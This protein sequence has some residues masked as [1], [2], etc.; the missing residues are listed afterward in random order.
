M[1]GKKVS[2]ISVGLMCLFILIS[3]SK[4]YETITLKIDFP[5]QSGDLQ[6]YGTLLS[7][8]HK[9]P[10]ET[11][12]NFAVV[13]NDNFTAKFVI[14]P[15]TAYNIGYN[16][17]NRLRIDGISVN[18]VPITSYCVINFGDSPE[19]MYGVASFIL[20]KDN[21]GQYQVAPDPNCNAIVR[22]VK[23]NITEERSEAL[24][25]KTV[26][27]SNRGQLIHYIDLEPIPNFWIPIG[28]TVN[29][30]P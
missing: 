29:C 6:L 30:E 7:P 3:C 1:K 22:K 11:P 8:K 10:W 23:L 25:E 13:A 14:Q 15:E 18:G 24:P 12:M 2:L 21:K 16:L 19:K 4:R 5:S 26:Y 20:K 9:A 17:D 28:T 27:K